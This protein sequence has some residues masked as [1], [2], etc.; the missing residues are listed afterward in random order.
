MVGDYGM[1]KTLFGRVATLRYSNFNADILAIG[2]KDI[3]TFKSLEQGLK[4][5]HYSCQRNISTSYR[6][7]LSV[8][9]N[10][11][12]QTNIFVKK[13]F[14]FKGDLKDV[15]QHFIDHKDYYGDL[16]VLLS[17]LLDKEDMV[18][19]EKDLSGGYFNLVANLYQNFSHQASVLTALKELK[20]KVNED[21]FN[22]GLI[23]AAVAE[24]ISY[25]HLKNYVPEANIYY[26]DANLSEPP[27]SEDMKLRFLYAID[28]FMEGLILVVD[29]PFSQLDPNL[30]KIIFN[31]LVNYAKN[32]NAVVIILDEKI[33]SD[34]IDDNRGKDVLGKILR[35][36]SDGFSLNVKV[37]DLE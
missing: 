24:Y 32:Y 15:K 30:S 29:E 12:K 23:L 21:I 11:A 35:F 3:R 25:N 6:N 22:K 17:G 7:A 36:E 1:G 34:V 14:N 2:D 10:D 9:I 31:D 8:Y 20:D 33:N 26:M 19:G 27:I 28:V 18:F 5:L 37:N 13:V 4:Y 16:H